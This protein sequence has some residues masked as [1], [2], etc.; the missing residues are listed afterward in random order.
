MV[1]Y[2]RIQSYI[3]SCRRDRQG[4]TEALIR[5]LYDSARAREIPVIRPQTE[6]T[7]RALLA[8]KQPV[9]ALEI[10][11]AIGY[12]AIITLHAAGPQAQLTG[13]EFDKIRAKEAEKNLADFGFAQR[14][15]VLNMDAE[16]ALKTLPDNTYDY[17]FVDAAKGQYM[18]YL[19]DVMRVALP[20]ALILSDNILQD[21]T[22]MESRYMVERRDRTIHA[23]MRDYV[24]EITHRDDLATTILPVGDGL[25]LS[26]KQ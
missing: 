21:F 17:V 4:E 10:G 23:R 24:Y 15:Q 19:P 12:S 22:I 26:V 2:E 1:D 11:T 25:A 16:A 9:R 13:I 3:S 7:I 8:L 20:G 6:E 14:A 5:K 18:N